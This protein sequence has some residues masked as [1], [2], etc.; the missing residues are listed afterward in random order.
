MHRLSA[1]AACVA[2]LVIVVAPASLAGAA[3]V[4]YDLALY[5]AYVWRGLTVTDGAVLQPAVDISHASGVSLN[6]WGNLDLDDVNDL[7][8]ELSEIDLTLAYEVPTGSALGLEVGWI[9]YLFPSTG[10]PTTR[11]V[12]VSAGLDLVVDPFLEVYYDFG[13]IDGT[14]G[15]IGLT[16][17]G[18][19]SDKVGWEAA[20]S[21][22]YADS[23][24]SEGYGGS[25]SGWYDGTA[26]L[27][28]TVA[29][30]DVVSLDGF[31]Q[32]VES[33]DDEVLPEAGPE[34]GGHDVGVV[35]RGSLVISL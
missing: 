8:G 6:V 26:S 33:L 12:Y 19:L 13:Q 2:L 22:G 25:G 28:V 10:Y 5:S 9:E 14:Y 18:D 20:A 35:G 15:Q 30:S 1:P 17:G 11:E 21:A 34:T 7:A 4:E 29:V 27:T 24:F 31:V 3:D 23:A 16:F 32:F